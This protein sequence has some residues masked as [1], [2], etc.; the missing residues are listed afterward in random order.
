MKVL[1]VREAGEKAG[2]HS[3]GAAW[4]WLRRN[5]FRLIRMGRRGIA[6]RE[7]DLEKFFEENTEDPSKAASYRP[8]GKAAGAA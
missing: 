2:K 1:S 7:A 6:V 4:K 8:D 5:K 3:Y